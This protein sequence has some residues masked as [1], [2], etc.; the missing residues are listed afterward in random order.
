MEEIFGEWKNEDDRRALLANRWIYE[1][2]PGAFPYISQP[3]KIL[4]TPVLARF[5]WPFFRK[6]DRQHS[7][8]YTLAITSGQLAPLF[9]GSLISKG[10]EHFLAGLARQGHVPIHDR[11]YHWVQDPSPNGPRVFLLIRLRQGQQQMT[12]PASGVSYSGLFTSTGRSLITLFRWFSS[13]SPK[14]FCNLAIFVHFS[15]FFWSAN[16]KFGGSRFSYAFY[17][18]NDFLNFVYFY[19]ANIIWSA[20]V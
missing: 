20:S 2:F 19:P 8:T 4:N 11:I 13:D 1:I 16:V 15:I 7:S 6:T 3:T 17:F 12:A 14:M 18:S 10:R 5:T 9:Q